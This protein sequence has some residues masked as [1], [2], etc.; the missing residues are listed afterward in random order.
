MCISDAL[1]A[2]QYQ[3]HR[4]TVPSLFAISGLK[5]VKN[6]FRHF[7]RKEKLALLFQSMAYLDNLET[8]RTHDVIRVL[9]LGTC[10]LLSQQQFALFSQFNLLIVGKLI[11]FI[12]LVAA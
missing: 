6:T 7:K 8:I 12:N 10:S 11:D 1:S 2:C 5:N 4:L 3:S 9:G